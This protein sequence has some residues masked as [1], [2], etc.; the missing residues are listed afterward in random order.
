MNQSGC[1]RLGLTAENLRVT[2]VVP[3]YNEAD[4]LAALAD[5][6]FE[7]QLPNFQ[8]LVVDDN[9]PDGTGAVADQLA[10]SSATRV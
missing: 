4:N 6:L 3:T 5:V 1:G 7:L 9:S 8:L 2:V 10:A